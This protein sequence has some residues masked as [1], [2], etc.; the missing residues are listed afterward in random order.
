MRSHRLY[1]ASPLAVGTTFILFLTMDALVGGDEEL[2]LNDAQ[3]R[4]FVDYVQVETPVEPERIDR[5]VIKP[6]EVEPIDDPVVP[7]IEL[8]D[9]DVYA[10]APPKPTDEF[11]VK[12]DGFGF[13]SQ[14]D[15]ELIPVVRV[16]APYPTRAAE[17]GIEGYVAVELTVGTDGAVAANS[18]R[19]VDAEPK[20][21]FERAAIKAAGKFKYK[22]KVVNGIAQEVS[23]V[24]YHFSF[25][26]QD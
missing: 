4:R 1:A 20:G 6:P 9:P 7:D 2:N 8:G 10:V 15:G 13:G 11:K 23:G 21:Y 17:R 19:V 25:N 24:R 14:S 16:A 3:P 5:E 18:V 22:P 12:P 26:L